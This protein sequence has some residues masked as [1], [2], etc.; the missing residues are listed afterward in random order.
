MTTKLHARTSI[1]ADWVRAALASGWGPEWARVPLNPL[2][3]WVGRSSGDAWLVHARSQPYVLKVRVSPEEQVDPAVFPVRQKVM[4]H[5]RRHGVPAPN[6]VP[7]AD[8]GGI[9]WREELAC[10]LTPVLKGA[11]PNHSGPDQVAAVVRT[12]L[13]LRACLDETPA[14]LVAALATVAS[15]VPPCWRTAVETARTHLL[16]Q[17]AQRRDDWGR[18]C[19]AMLRG[20]I[21]AEP[22]M[23]ALPAR[24]VS[25]VVHGSLCGKNFVL[26]GGRDP[27][28]LGVQDFGALHV[29]DPL[30]D[31]AALA[32]TAARVRVGETAQRRAL[33][34][35]LDLA[36]RGGLLAEG[37]EQLLMPLLL[38]RTVPP[39][40]EL[41]RAVLLE[42]RRG[43]SLIEQFDLFD[44]M[45]KT[46]VHRLLTGPGW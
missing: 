15:P 7:T 30:L 37:Q 32:D 27:Q 14:H 29:G 6:P 1:D 45:H 25:A 12:G 44:P 8:G 3:D 17:A 42:D 21:A 33:A 10:E 35:F 5:C 23:A 34:V 19:A 9:A 38:T 4:A 11:V 22:L 24:P 26:S 13:L 41:V 28:V 20:V 36:V 31:L 18:A 16:P 43:Q 46:H 39:L 40:V 2:A